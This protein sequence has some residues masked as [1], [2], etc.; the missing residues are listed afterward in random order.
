MPIFNY[1]FIVDAPLEEVAAFHQDTSVLKK[2]SP[3]P[4]FIQLHRF[5]PLQEG[6]V[7]EFT[8]WLGPIPL[9]WTA[10]HSN[11]DRLHGFTDTQAKGPLKSWAHTHRFDTLSSNKTK[12]TEHIEYEY[13]DGL[14]GIFNRLLFAPPALKFLFFYRKT[15]TR[16]LI[17]NNTYTFANS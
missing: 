2:L 4:M 12:V 5:D 11:F 1:E 15:V 3:P 8:M 16:R 6:A 7:A 17:K 10:V 14:M 13:A 9:H